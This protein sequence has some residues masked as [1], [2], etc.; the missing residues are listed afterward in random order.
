MALT[1]WS[2]MCPRKEGQIGAGSTFSVGIEQMVRPRI[3]LID[4]FLDQPHAKHA[5]V[6]IEVLLRRPGNGGD[7]MKSVYSSH[8]ENQQALS[9]YRT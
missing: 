2:E 5:R 6:E 3:V 4:A 8:R 1:G 7:V 9:G